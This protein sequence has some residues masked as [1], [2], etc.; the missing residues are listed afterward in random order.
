MFLGHFLKQEQF[1]QKYGVMDDFG[2]PKMVWHGC[3]AGCEGG[4]GL[5]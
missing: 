3:S 4:K 1:E 2:K 5:V